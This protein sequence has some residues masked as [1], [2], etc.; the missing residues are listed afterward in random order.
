MAALGRNG[1]SKVWDYFEVVEKELCEGVNLAY[2]RG[3]QLIY[4][5]TWNQNT[6]LVLLKVVERK[7]GRNN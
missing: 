5:T 3:E 7:L 6:H 4:I 2:A 1:T